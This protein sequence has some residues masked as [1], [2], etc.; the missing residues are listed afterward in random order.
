MSKI[1]EKIREQ[2]GEVLLSADEFAKDEQ[3]II[4]TTPKL[5]VILGGGI[6]EGSFC[7]ITGPPKGGKSSFAIH[8]AGNAQKY[9]S[10]FGK[11]KVFYLDI[12]GRIK[13]RD[14][15]NNVILNT[16]NDKFRL[17]R[18]TPGHILTGDEFI[19]IGEQLIKSEPGCI[20]IFDSF[21]AI[22]TS[23]ESTADIKE[24]YRADS[25]LLLARFCRRISQVV[26][27]NKSIV[28]GIT[29]I[30]ANQ[31][32]QGPRASKWI[33][34][35]GRKLQY[36][37]DVKLRL[38][39]FLPWKT[40]ESQIGQEVFWDCE[41]TPL[42]TAGMSTNSF[43]RYGHG[44][45]EYKEICDLGCDLGIVQKNGAWY[46]Y[47]EEKYHGAEKFLNMLRESRKEFDKLRDKI[48]TFFKS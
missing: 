6:P 2:F 17:I 13:R 16:D 1:E 29:H 36:Q 33:E 34:A 12:E 45:D 21:S 23:G 44:F 9:D 43:L 14:L 27:I 28:I 31:A 5:D 15:F 48:N 19:D 11:R 47:E 18:S 3:V 26:S 22:C 7:I 41:T 10:S 46:I 8:I 30:I 35:S 37:A 32:G 20:F 40:G 42:G 39:Y 25:P 24:R 38:A 4:P